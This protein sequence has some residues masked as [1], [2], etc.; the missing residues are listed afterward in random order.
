M[1]NEL[2][3]RFRYREAKVGFT[4]DF[5]SLPEASKQNLE[6]DLV[7]VAASGFSRLVSQEFSLDVADHIRGGDL[8]V[9][10]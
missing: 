7:R 1:N 10:E 2:E 6:P 5:D 9:I 3:H 8:Y 4:S